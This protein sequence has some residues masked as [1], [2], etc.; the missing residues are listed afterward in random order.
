MSQIDH[1]PVMCQAVVSLLAPRP[2]F[3]YLDCTLGRAGHAVAIAAHLAPGG[4]VI[5]LDLDPANIEHA[6]RALADC[7]VQVELVHANFADARRVLDRLGVDG[8]DLLLADL[9]FASSQV[10]DP[11]RGLSFQ[12][13]GPLD[14]RLD[15]HRQTTAADLVNRLSERELAD[16]IYQYGEER[17]SRRIARRVVEARAAEPIRTT[18]QLARIVRSAARRPGAK[19][20]GHQRIDPATRTFMALRIAVNAELDNLDA[21]LAQLPDLLA[22]EGTAAFISFHSLEDRRVKQALLELDRRGV[23][24]RL[25]RKPIVADEQEKSINPRSRSAR[26]RGFRMKPDQ[27]ELQTRRHSRA[28]VNGSRPGA[29]G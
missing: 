25:T 28:A 15:P 3:R 26:L 14:M 21:L 16:L 12:A 2:G 24:R 9:G 10:D 8:V 20:G 4:R 5:G 7:P 19:R 18:E 17:L 13:D 29:A 23:G 6:R 27:A 22:P 11:R 1:I